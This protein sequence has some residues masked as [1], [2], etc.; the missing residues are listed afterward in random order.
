MVRLF[1]FCIVLVIFQHTVVL[2]YANS[3][4]SKLDLEQEFDILSKEVLLPGFI[5]L[6][7][8][9]I[10]NLKGS[11]IDEVKAK[12]DIDQITGNARNILY[13]EELAPEGPLDVMDFSL[14]WWKSHS[15]IYGIMNRDPDKGKEYLWRLVKDKIDVEPTPPSPPDLL[16]PQKRI[17]KNPLDYSSQIEPPKIPPPDL[18][19]LTWM[20][21][22]TKYQVTLK[23]DK[24]E[25]FNIGEWRYMQK[26]NWKK[27]ALVAITVG[28]LSYILNG[29]SKSKSKEIEVF[30]YS[31]SE[32]PKPR[33]WTAV[34]LGEP[35]WNRPTI[36]PGITLEE[37][38][39]RPD[40]QM[41]YPTPPII[42]DTVIVY[43]PP[44]WVPV[45]RN[46]SIAISVFY[47]YRAVYKF[48]RS[49]FF[50]INKLP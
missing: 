22:P 19:D 3:S 21:N 7:V 6:N 13:G 39:Q 2:L 41:W 17:S 26:Q 47:G 34:A 23:Y 20:P 49:K 48:F 30:A 46:I 45:A 32:G 25:L 29:L 36:P 11:T 4:Q 10:E 33:C 9:N 50:P 27:D 8:P 35:I 16:Y 42:T 12:V 31:P 38:R 1:L 43:E 37:W 5:S 24:D 28:G 14:E 18:P 40:L 15:N 44:G